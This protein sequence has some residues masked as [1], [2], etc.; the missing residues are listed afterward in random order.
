MKIAALVERMLNYLSRKGRA[1]VL[2][3]IGLTAEER[4]AI[5]DALI[6]IRARLDASGESLAAVHLSQVLDFLVPGDLA[7]HE[8]DQGASDAATSLHNSRTSE[9]NF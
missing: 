3:R 9:G 6:E 8:A 7:T 4:S 1:I 5:V 2:S